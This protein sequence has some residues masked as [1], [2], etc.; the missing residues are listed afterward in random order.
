[1]AY[2]PS[3]IKFIPGINPEPDSTNQNTLHIIDGDNIRFYQAS[4]EKLGGHVKEPLSVLDLQG[5]NLGSTLSGCGRALRSYSKDNKKWQIEGTHT[6]LYAKL[7]GDVWNITPLKTTATA[8]LGADPLDTT[9]TDETLTVNYTAHGLAVGDR[10]KLTGATDVG[11][12]TAANDINREHIIGTVPDANSFTI[13]LENAATSTASGGGASIEIFTEIDAGGCDAVNATGYGVGTYG[14][15]DFGESQTDTTLFVQP[16]IW[17]MDVFGTTLVCGAGQGGKCYQW[18]SDVDTAPT[19][20]TNA[21]DADWGWVED[22]KLVT[23]KD[24]IIKN[25]NTGDLTDWTPAAG[26]SAYEDTKEDAH[27]LIGRAFVNG[28]NLIFAEE[29]KIFR[30]RWVGGTVKWSWVRVDAEVGI[31]SPNSYVVRGGVC[32]IFGRDDVY[33]YNGGMLQPIPNNTLRK[34][35]YEDINTD[36]R[37]KFFSWHNG[38]PYN[39]VHMHYASANSDENDRAVIFHLYENWWSKRDSIER[40]AVDLSLIHI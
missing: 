36:Q 27:K 33:S 35:L 11:G 15:N 19:V 14:T 2:T 34:Y 1:M 38:K 40:T 39:E 31:M 6:K 10:I 20:I 26:S 24:N 22:A 28:E 21:P 8:T 4:V 32:I 3:R 5:A 18:L 25:S 12:I 13:E 29:K 9:D 16:R 7:G 23:L 17:W 30:L 37:F